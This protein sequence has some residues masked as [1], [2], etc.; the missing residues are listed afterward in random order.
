MK[1]IIASLVLTALLT[2]CHQ[3]DQKKPD[4]PK[5]SI[6]GMNMPMTPGPT[7]VFKILMDSMM[8]R[9]EAMDPSASNDL[10]FAKMMLVHHQGAVDMAKLE[11][12]EGKDSAMQQFSGQVIAAQE[13]EI[14]FMTDFISRTAPVASANAKQFRQAIQASMQTMMKDTTAS[15]NDADKDFA[16]QMIPHHQSAVDMAKAY[17]QSGTNT[18]LKTL[19]QHIL[20]SQIEEIEWLKSWLANHKS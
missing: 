1:K 3:S 10:Y 7:N 17:L 14:S 12:E 18:E 9:M 16:A 15:Y 2:A 8:Q 13:K 11:Q 20:D 19:S 4:A 6:I 5:D